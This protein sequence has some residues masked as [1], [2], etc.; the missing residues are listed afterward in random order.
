MLTQEL[1]HPIFSLILLRRGSER[2]AGWVG[3][4]WSR[5][6]HHSS[7]R[8]GTLCSCDP[9]VLPNQEGRE[10]S[11]CLMRAWRQEV[12]S[13]LEESNWAGFGKNK[14]PLA[15]ITSSTPLLSQQAEFLGP[16]ACLHG[17]PC[18]SLLPPAY[19]FGGKAWWQRLWACLY[20]SLVPCLCL[21]STVE[22]QK[23]INLVEDISGRN[24]SLSL[25][26]RHWKQNKPI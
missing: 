1:S 9:L 3:S 13:S 20:P 23:R 16:G 26:W 21:L 19:P 5:L 11:H 25:H 8:Y 4:S 15:L 14:S 24:F 12:D 7:P 2:V 6:T 17:G 22:G 18:P 10:G